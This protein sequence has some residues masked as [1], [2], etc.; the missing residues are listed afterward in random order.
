MPVHDQLLGST[1]PVLSI[2]L[3]P[4]ES[5]VAE[6]G[7]FAWMTDS[8][9]MAAGPAGLSAYTAKDSAG[10]IAFASRLPGSIVCLE[11]SP[12]REYLVHRRGFL[13]GTPGI[14]VTTGFRQPLRTASRAADEFVL[15]RI[16]GSG[17]AWVDLSGDVVR[18]DLVAGTSLRTHP[19]HIGIC[20]ASVAVQ[21]AEL[22]SPPRLT[23]QR[24]PPLR[25]P[26]RSW[27]RLAAVDAAARA[28]GPV[29]S[30]GHCARRPG[31]RGGSR[32]ARRAEAQSGGMTTST[33]MPS[34][35]HI[36]DRGKKQMDIRMHYP[37]RRQAG[38][39][40]ALAAAAGL[41]PGR[42]QHRELRLVRR[43]GLRD[44]QG[45]RQQVGRR[46]GFERLRQLWRLDISRLGELG[47]VPDRASGT[48]GSTPT[49]TA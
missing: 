7:E 16:G 1:Q 33:D 28:P 4:G 5:I 21:M 46:T 41:D 6:T 24:R 14:E 11:I 47:A 43:L 12:E 10:T 22:A 39:A 48:P 3:E 17:R 20:E 36:K 49:R 9:Q 45:R 2:S 34:T 31:C 44:E 13:A 23:R 32:A 25:R 35:A 27:I 29:V 40:A 26:I 30:A 19:W 38:A 42:L 15:R 8:I 37:L 18:R